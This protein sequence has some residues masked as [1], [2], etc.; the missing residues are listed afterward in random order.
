MPVLPLEIKPIS[1]RRGRDQIV[2]DLCCL[3]LNGSVIRDWDGVAQGKYG[4]SKKKDVAQRTTSSRIDPSMGLTSF[5]GFGLQ[6]LFKDLR[7]H[8]NEQFSP[9]L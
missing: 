9:L 5:L 7:R 6:G 3:G 2:L 1:Q 4:A 8:E